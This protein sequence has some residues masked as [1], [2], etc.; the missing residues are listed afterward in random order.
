VRLTGRAVLGA[1]SSELSGTPQPGAPVIA[2]NCDVLFGSV[3]VR[4]P[5]CI[6]RRRQAREAIQSS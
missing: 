4:R 2:V 1:K 5:D 6:M 3:T